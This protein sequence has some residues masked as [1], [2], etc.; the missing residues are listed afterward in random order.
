MV[1]LADVLSKIDIQDLLRQKD[2]ASL[3]PVGPYIHGPGGLFGV[4]GLSRDVISTRVQPRGLLGVLPTRGTTDMNPLFPYITGFQAVTGSTKNNVCDDPETAG[5]I[6]NCLQTAAFGRYELQTRTLERNR[7][8][9]QINRGE[10]MDLNIVNSPLVGG[11]GGITSPAS[12]SGGMFD[13]N[14]E[15]ASRF[16]EV[17]VGFENY[18]IR[19][20]YTGNPANNSAG[21]GYREPP[22]L[23]ILIGTTKV[24][25]VQG[26]PCPTLRSDIKDFNYAR[27]DAAGGQTA[28]NVFT[29]LVRTRKS[30]A[31]RTNMGQ[32]QWVFAM[33]E[34]LF[35]EL[36]AVWPCAYL[37]Y[38][39]QQ[40]TNNTDTRLVIDSQAQLQ[41]RNDMRNGQY[42]IIDDIKYPVVF[43]D[44][45]VEENAADNAAI[46]ATCFASDVYFIPLTIRNGTMASTFVEHLDYSATNGAMTMA[47]PRD[48]WT[49]G[50]RYMWHHKPPNNWCEQWL[51]K[52]EWRVIM[53]T[54][55]L[56]GRITNIQYCPLQHT[57]DSIIGDDYFVDGGVTNRLPGTLYSDWNPTTPA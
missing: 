42:L 8:G 54:P 35:Y 7:L 51:A 38:R 12:A 36:T 4:A 18:L 13:L 11:A 1:S 43:D 44:G 5:P 53:L 31:S 52:L 37:T 57:N 33:R 26:T 24:D 55:H 40:Q 15:V 41:L 29:Y 10:F 32:V 16:V 48:F 46:A 14:N 21:G 39:C 28:V 45:I 47:D 17:G 30:L 56:A 6:K 19:R 20:L 50:G 2:V 22:G 27:V 9:Q 34:E 49:D 25:A 23:D 3:P